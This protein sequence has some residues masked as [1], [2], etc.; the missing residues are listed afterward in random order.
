MTNKLERIPHVSAGDVER[1]QYVDPNA[2]AVGRWYWLKLT[3]E[4]RRQV[5]ERKNG[6]PKWEDYSVE[7]EQL[8][9]V[10]HVGSNFATLTW[11]TLDSYSENHRTMSTRVHFDTFEE[12][13]RPERDPKTVIDGFTRTH[14]Q[15]ALFLMEQVQEITERLALG[16]GK[17]SSSESG[18]QLAVVGAGKEGLKKY[19]AALVKA[20]DKELPEL[21]K[22]ISKEN[23]SIAMWMVASLIPMQAQAEGLKPLVKAINSRIFNVELY[24]GLVETVTQVKE[25]LPAPS[26]EKIHLFQ[27]RHYMDEECLANYETGGMVFEDIGEFDEWLTRQDNLD[28]ILP[29]PRCVVAFRVRRYKK[30]REAES[31]SDL[32]SISLKEK[33]DELT[34]LYMRNGQRVYRLATGIEFDE[35]LFPDPERAHLRGKL[36]V[37]GTTLITEGEYLERKETYARQRKEMA[38]DIRSARRRKIPKGGKWN[39]H[40]VKPDGTKA[41]VV[42]HYG[43]PRI[44]DEAY[45]Y[46]PFTPAHI[47]YDD[48]R[49][50]M[51]ADIESHNRIVLI[52]QGL[53]DRSMV[54]HPHPRLNLMVEKDFQAA[55]EL[56]YDDSRAIAPGEAPDFEA[57]RVKLN[58]Q[59]KPGDVVVGQEDEWLKYEAERYRND[60]RRYYNR[61]DSWEKERYQPPGNPGPGYLARCVS[62]TRTGKVT[63]KWQ[64]ERQTPKS[65]KWWKYGHQ[66]DIIPCSFTVDASKVFNV[67]AYKPGDF[68]RFY[69]DPRTRADY[70]KWAPLLLAA[71]E[72]HA[73]NRTLA[74]AFGATECESINGMVEREDYGLYKARDERR[75]KR[76]QRKAAA[77]DVRNVENPPV[78]EPDEPEDEDVV[79]DEDDSDSDD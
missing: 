11:P 67:S 37:N 16:V 49:A 75:K 52:L 42:R 61:R 29:K 68:K 77:L 9:C 70:V 8:A 18:S 73:G 22:Q 24:A 69:A 2:P 5:G 3:V 58:A 1:E 78:E 19:E 72:W 36:Y 71:E 13:C 57:Y 54:F 65:R 48:I 38:A 15:K 34:F 47:N 45:G 43:Y 7:I 53:L 56:V 25:G 39:E 46:T 21:F 74:P 12:R 41:Q 31:I 27:R 63:F 33:Q 79:E 23:Q 64:R 59:L 10:T 17:Q 4:K 20:K 40:E 30:A 32:L 28:R 66:Q 51:Q 26:T 76:K 62:V 35:Q 6:E 14:Q 44:R 60:S 50:K 55:L